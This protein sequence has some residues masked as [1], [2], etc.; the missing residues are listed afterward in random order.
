LRRREGRSEL[1]GFL[2]KRREEL[3]LEETRRGKNKE[4]VSRAKTQRKKFL[5]KKAGIT[6][7]QES[8]ENFLEF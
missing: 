2:S 8:A 5:K 3:F 6:L 1:R 4:K 7:L